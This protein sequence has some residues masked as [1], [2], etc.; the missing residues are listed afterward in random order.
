VSEDLFE[1][2]DTDDTRAKDKLIAFIEEHDLAP[3]L[4]SFKKRPYDMDKRFCYSM[5]AEDQR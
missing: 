3:I 1:Y 5:R 4:A 2:V